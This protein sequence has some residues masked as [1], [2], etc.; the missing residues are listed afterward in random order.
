M[1]NCLVNGSPFVVGGGTIAAL[2]DEMQLQ[3]RKIAVEKNGVI[4]PKSCHGEEPLQDGDV[5]EIVTA[6][7]GG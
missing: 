3:G 2:L 5:I 4:V 6:V 7:G 1:A